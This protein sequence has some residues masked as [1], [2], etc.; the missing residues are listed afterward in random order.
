MSQGW[1]S[2][3]AAPLADRLVFSK[4]RAGL[5][6]RIKLWVSGAAQLPQ[7]VSEAAVL[8]LLA[9]ESLTHSAAG[10]AIKLT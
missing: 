2:R 3:A 6:G 9:S 1:P 8:L 5:G 10:Q 4:V 7:H